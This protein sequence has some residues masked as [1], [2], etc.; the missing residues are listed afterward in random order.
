MTI[1]STWGSMR[2]KY[3]PPRPTWNHDAYMSSLKLQ[4]LKGAFLMQGVNLPWSC[5]FPD[6]VDVIRQQWI[7]SEPKS[8]CSIE[9]DAAGQAVDTVQLELDY[10]NIL[11]DLVQ[12]IA[13]NAADL[14]YI[15]SHPQLKALLRKRPQEIESYLDA[16]VV[17]LNSAKGII[18]LLAVGFSLLAD[19]VV[20]GD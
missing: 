18:K 1:T 5:E 16:N 10:V 3:V 19:Q 11:T 17:N 14:Q 7:T 2:S 15:R 12:E 9:N 6:D 8:V 13:D 4:A 20:D